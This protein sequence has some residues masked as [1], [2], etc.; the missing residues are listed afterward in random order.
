M[1]TLASC[2]ITRASERAIGILD[3]SHHA[4]KKEE[5]FARGS[6]RQDIIARGTEMESATILLADDEAL[7]LIEFEG[8]L[9]DAGFLVLA[10]TSA[11]QA[12]KLLNSEDSEIAGVVTDIRFGSFPDG[13]EVARVARENDA[14]MPVVYISG[15]GLLDWQAM[16]VANSIMLE[17]PFPLEKLVTTVSQLLDARPPL[18]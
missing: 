3:L 14:D 5:L 13:W 6:V 2:R 11:S 18:A 9:A 1:V 4:N 7:L 17:K 10:V 12:I 16:G 15:H 8:A